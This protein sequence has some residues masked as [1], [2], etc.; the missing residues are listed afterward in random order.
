MGIAIQSY[1]QAGDIDLLCD[2]IDGGGPNRFDINGDGTLDN[3]DVSFLVETLLNTKFGD[4]DTDGDVDLAD[5]G[6]LASGFG[7]AGEK[8]W[9]R[10]NFD[11]DDDVDLNDL[12]TLATNF[13][14]GRQAALS[15]FESLVPEP[16]SML[17][18]AVLAGL[19][20]RRA[21]T[22]SARFPRL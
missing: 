17:M 7:V 14:A 10:G 5:L 11:C 3:D 20:G 18:L 2:A 1:S 13:E 4:S 15:Q 19:L 21:A 16:A 6:N 12:G 9:S 8:R 22:S